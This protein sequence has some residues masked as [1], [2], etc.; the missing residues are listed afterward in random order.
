MWE[1]VPRTAPFIFE[2]ENPSPSMSFPEA[3]FS[4]SSISA[5]RGLIAFLGSAR[6]RRLPSAICLGPVAFRTKAAIGELPDRAV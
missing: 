2:D 1:V 4:A 5:L 3:D 6:V